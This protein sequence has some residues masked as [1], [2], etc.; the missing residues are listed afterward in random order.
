M[1]ENT[2]LQAKVKFMWVLGR[3]LWYCGCKRIASCANIAVV[4]CQ[5]MGMGAE[6]NS[7]KIFFGRTIWKEA[8][9]STVSEENLGAKV[10]KKCSDAA[11]C[12]L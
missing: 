12:E 1:P 9:K 3:I 4:G 5:S 6:E 8:M 7:A 10:T 11:R 2:I